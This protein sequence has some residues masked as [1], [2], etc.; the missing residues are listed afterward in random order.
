M[1]EIQGDQLFANGDEIPDVPGDVDLEM[2]GKEINFFSQAT[3]ATPASQEL[4][5]SLSASD[6]SQENKDELCSM[7]CSTDSEAEP[8]H[9]PESDKEIE[10]EIMR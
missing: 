10:I 8:K 4:Q 5:P 2:D 7:T 6:P 3:C 1:V 9:E